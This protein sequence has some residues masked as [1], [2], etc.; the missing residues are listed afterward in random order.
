MST[1]T[2]TSDGLRTDEQLWAEGFLHDAGSYCPQCGNEALGAALPNV[3][4]TYV[5]CWGKDTPAAVCCR[6]CGSGWCKKCL[7]EEG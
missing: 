6:K 5:T 1:W 4:C 3:V 7:G 2:L